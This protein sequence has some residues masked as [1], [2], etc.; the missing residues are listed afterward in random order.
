M[1]GSIPFAIPSQFAA[2]IA[3]GSIVRIGAILK[4]SSSGQVLAHVQ[5]TGLTHALLKGVASSP[6]SPISALSS[7][8]SNVQLAHVTKL[9]EGLQ[10]LQ[11]ASIGASVAGL[12]VSAVGFVL[13][14]KKLNKIQDQIAKMSAQM[15]LHFEEIKERELRKH[16]SVI[17]GLYEQ[18]ENASFLKDPTSEWLRVASGLSLQRAYFLGELTHLLKQKRFDSMLFDTLITSYG[19]C[20]AGRTECLLLA[21]EIEAAVKDAE[22]TA[23]HY[24]MFDNL[25]PVDLGAKYQTSTSKVRELIN[26]IRDAQDAAFTKPYLL[27]TLIEKDIDSRSY[28]TALREEHE[29]P[30]VLLKAA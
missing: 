7:S 30:L 5:E 22:T 3:D 1:I 19:I 23:Q 15:N 2:G 17:Y 24:T 16:Y 21:R 25:N 26:G 27:N 14:N 10:I 12:G 6:F 20:S 13:M 8:I 18:A 4:D 29:H 28:V 9:V 11:Y